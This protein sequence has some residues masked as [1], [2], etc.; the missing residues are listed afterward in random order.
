MN[1]KLIPTLAVIF[2]VGIVILSIL[3]IALYSSIK[4][5]AKP[6]IASFADCAAAGNPILESY[7]EQCNTSY[8]VHFVN[9][10]PARVTVTGTIE[11]LP[12]KDRGEVQTLEC[13]F[14]IKDSADNHYALSDPDWR[15]LSDLPTGKDAVVTGTIKPNP[16]NNIYDTVFTIEISNIN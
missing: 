14:G 3:G 6:A 2:L 10:K 16:V 13:A 1:K 5:V 8:R 7:P 11:C 9:S 4:P 12:H 15:W